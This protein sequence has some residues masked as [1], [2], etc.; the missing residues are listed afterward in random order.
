MLGYWLQIITYTEINAILALGFYVI[1]ASG[2]FPFCCGAFMGIGAYF[3]AIFTVKFG[4]YYPISLFAGAFTAAL[5]AYILS[6][7]LLRLKGMFFAIATLAFGEAVVILFYNWEYVGGAM[8]FRGIPLKTTTNIVFIVLAVTIYFF[9]RFHNSPLYKTFTA[10]KDDEIA[11][12]AVGINLFKYRSYSFA[13][14]AFFCG[15]GGGLMAHYLGI[16]EPV[17]FGIV[18]STDIFLYSVIGGTEVFVGSIFGSFLLTIFPEVTRFIA[19]QRFIIY[20]ILLV[21][22]VIYRPQGLIDKS[23]LKKISRFFDV[24]IGRW[25]H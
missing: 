6:L 25:F 1:F 10:I 17:D 2:Q 22:V 7:P 12:S 4:S 15:L 8:G 21:V 18:Q 24:T 23:I 13:L 9:I 20:G 5:V 11:A 14:G 16:I 3:S 19:Q